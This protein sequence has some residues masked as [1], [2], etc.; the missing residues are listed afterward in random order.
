VCQQRDLYAGEL[1]K[2][3]E[4]LQIEKIKGADKLARQEETF[5]HKIEQL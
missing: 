4:E 3:E 5:N 2:K 1:H